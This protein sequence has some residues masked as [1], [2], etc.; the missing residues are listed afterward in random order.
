M[1][2]RLSVCERSFIIGVAQHAP[3]GE[4]PL[5]GDHWLLVVLC[6]VA[7]VFLGPLRRTYLGRSTRMEGSLKSDSVKVVAKTCSVGKPTKGT[8]GGGSGGLT[9]TLVSAFSSK[10][11]PVARSSMM[12]THERTRSSDPSELNT[13]SANKEAADECRT[14]RPASSASPAMTRRPV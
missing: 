5:G 3:A 2:P 11:Y 4:S 13:G 7:A 12:V 14:A 6:R 10:G 1:N 9:L 8:P